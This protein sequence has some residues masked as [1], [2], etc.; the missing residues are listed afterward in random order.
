MELVP[1]EKEPE[2]APSPL[3]LCENAANGAGY[4]PGRGS[5]LILNLP[6]PPS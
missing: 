5:S 3:P 2:K 6:V 4:E 1:L